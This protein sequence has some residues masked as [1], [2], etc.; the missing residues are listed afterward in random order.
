MSPSRLHTLQPCPPPATDSKFSFCSGFLPHRPGS[1]VRFLVGA[2][3]LEVRKGSELSR[4][5]K[6]GSAPR[7]VLASSAESLSFST[8]QTVH[9]PLTAVREFSFSSKT[10]PLAVYLESSLLLQQAQAAVASCP[11]SKDTDAMATQSNVSSR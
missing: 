1:P 2:M 3:A 8:G 9:A 10:V 7:P 6:K 4:E 5:R 11:P